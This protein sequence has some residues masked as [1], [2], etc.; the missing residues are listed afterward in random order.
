MKLFTFPS[1]LATSRALIF[2][3]VELMMKEPEKTFNIAISGGST[4]AIL[5]DLWANEYSSITPWE[6]MRIRFVDER[7]VPPTNSERNYKLVNDLLFIK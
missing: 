5:Y 7:C 3:I 4:P 6:R 2:R 1:Y